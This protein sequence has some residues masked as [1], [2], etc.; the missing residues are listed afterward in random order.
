MNED[1]GCTVVRLS[2]INVSVDNEDFLCRSKLLHFQTR[3]Q[4]YFL[5]NEDLLKENL[6]W[7][8]M[9]NGLT[10]TGSV[11]YSIVRGTGNSKKIWMAPDIIHCSGWMT[12]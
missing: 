5:E 3:L 2:G 1:T 7:M 10:I 8:K 11:L 4:I 9:R 6:F 12:G